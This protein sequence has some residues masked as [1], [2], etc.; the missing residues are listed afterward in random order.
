MRIAIV[1][2]SLRAVGGAE[3]VVI[4]LAESLVQ[5]G[6]M[7]TVFTR[8]FSEDVWGKIND[9]P[10]SVR[11]LDFKKYRST[12]KTNRNAGMS[13][14]KAL[15]PYEFD[16]VN[17]HNY[18]ASLW[19]HYA[20]AQGHEFPKVLLYLHNLT[21]N[22]YAKK[23]DIHLRELPGFRNT[24]NRYRPKILFR[25]LRQYLL[26]YKLLDKAAVQSCDSVLANSMYTANLAESIYGREVQFCP[27]GIPVERFKNQ[28]NDALQRQ[29][30]TG[31]LFTVLTVVRIETQKNL[32]TI[33]KAVK[34]LKKKNNLTK[35]FFYKIVGGGPHL[36]YFKQKSEKMGLNDVVHF[37]GPIPHNDIWKLYGESDIIVHVPLDEPFGLIPVEAAMMRKPSIVSDH[38]GPSEIVIDGL[39]GLHVQALSPEDL[40]EKIHN[41]MEQSYRLKAMGDAAYSRISEH[42]VWDVFITKF[43]LALNCLH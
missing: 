2:P 40:A 27:L 20:K 29:N 22:F 21:R 28:I 35:R 1:Y 9:R 38:G 23:I 13:L 32:D 19:V 10:Y 18:P 4:W 33:L 34:I 11:L 16:I 14:A 36:S 24:W 25:Y 41:L 37:L 31:D 6:H 5:R 42:Y 3:N 30:E 7:V 26:G 15:A 17:P 12:L 43:E 8:D 39:T